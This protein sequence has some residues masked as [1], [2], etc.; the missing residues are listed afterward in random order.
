MAR[1]KTRIEK[2]ERFSKPDRRQDPA[3]CAFLPNANKLEFELIMADI[4][5]REA[6]GQKVIT[7]S[8]VN[9]SE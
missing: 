4:A 3:Y 5:E 1:I 2:L 6:R 7:F 8:G 9:A